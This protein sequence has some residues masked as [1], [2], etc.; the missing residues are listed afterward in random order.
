V[1]HFINAIVFD[2]PVMVSAE[3]AKLVMEV[4]SAA[5]LSVELGEPVSLPRNDFK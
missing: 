5:D 4:Y 1:N 2:T 3:E